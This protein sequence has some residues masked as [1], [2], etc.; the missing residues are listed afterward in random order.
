MNASDLLQ[1]LISAERAY[2]EAVHAVQKDGGRLFREVRQQ[3][4]LTQRDFAA[5]LGVDFT[6]VSK[7][8]N[9][10]MRPGKPVLTRLAAWLAEQEPMVGERGSER[11]TE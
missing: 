11:G 4:K 10:H 7:V 2:R 1:R 5:L 3:Y 8:E 6:F 9:G